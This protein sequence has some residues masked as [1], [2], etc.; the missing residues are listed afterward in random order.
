[1][2]RYIATVVLL[3]LLLPGSARAQVVAQ[4]DA[5]LST[6][7][8]DAEAAQLM[9]ISRYYF[10]RR[11]YTGA[12]AR[13]KQVVKCCRLSQHTDEALARLAETYLAL[14]VNSEAQT[15]A[16]VLVRVYPNSR[17]SAVARDA[18][19]S[20]GLDPLENERSWISQAFK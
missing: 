6:E 10:D 19:R 18:V 17:W 13:Y 15:A 7:A 12:T 14:G 11:D 20:A 3:A 2:I 4:P 1:L 16:A 5:G 8:V 9:K